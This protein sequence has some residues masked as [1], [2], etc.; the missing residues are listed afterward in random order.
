M[1]PS[2]IHLDFP[3]M[4]IPFKFIGD[5]KMRTVD[6]EET[7]FNSFIWSREEGKQ[8]KKG[9]RCVD[10]IEQLQLKRRNIEREERAAK[11][12]VNNNNNN[13]NNNNKNRFRSI[14]WS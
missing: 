7:K 5:T 2:L 3:F 6:E 1:L 14:I 10:I 11:V 12:M 13:N 8:K 4:F 9:G